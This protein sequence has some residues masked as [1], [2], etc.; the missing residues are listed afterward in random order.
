MDGFYRA[1][2]QYNERVQTIDEKICQ[3]I[4]QRKNMSDQPGI[5]TEQLLHQWAK[6]FGFHEEFLVALFGILQAEDDFQPQIEPKGFVKMIPVL[7][8]FTKD[9]LFYAI[10]SIRQYQNASV[11]HVV[12]DHEVLDEEEEPVVH[13]LMGGDFM[14][15]VKDLEGTQYSCQNRGSGGFDGHTAF[16]FVITPPLPDKLEG[17]ELHLFEEEKDDIS[18]TCR[19]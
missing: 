9:Q 16:Q 15:R 10:T 11:L 12:V 13:T 5:P 2:Q 14:L 18:F 3:L 6:I 17:I 7:Q 1:R 19:F 8:S 4:A